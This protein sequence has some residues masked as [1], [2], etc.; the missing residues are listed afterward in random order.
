MSKLSQLIR[1]HVPD[2]VEYVALGEVATISNGKD[3][4]HLPD[5]EYPVYGSGGIMRYADKYMYD[6]ESV[7]IPRKGSISNIFYV[8]TPFWAVDTIFY[9]KISERIL[10]KFLY[11]YMTMI[12]V[13]D[14]NE[15]G[16]VPSLTKTV[17][18]KV[19]IPLPPLPIQNEIVRILDNF[20]ELINDLTQGLPAEI[21]AR[22]KQYEY[23]RDKL[24]NFEEA[25]S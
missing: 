8:N 9:T 11:Y 3:H 12:H 2:G 24:L 7:L 20:A 17:L 23:Y 15:A 25:A 22:R 10:P 19:R 13:E 4:K 21:A 1:Q 16:G 14:L 18:D 5:G 6:Q